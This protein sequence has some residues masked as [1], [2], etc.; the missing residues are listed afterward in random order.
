MERRRVLRSVIE[1][2]EELLELRQARLPRERVEDEE[3]QDVLVGQ[4]I[5]TV[6]LLSLEQFSN[7]GDELRPEVASVRVVFVAVGVLTDADNPN[8]TEENEHLNGN[9]DG[10]VF[11]LRPDEVA[12][13]LLL[14]PAVV[15][16]RAG[17]RADV[18]SALL[19]LG[20]RAAGRCRPIDERNRDALD[21]RQEQDRLK[22]R[23]V[24]ALLDVLPWLL[25]LTLAKD[26]DREVQRKAPGDLVVDGRDALVR[27]ERVDAR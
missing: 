15:H 5:P 11:D 19:V 25:V 26:E 9:F 3:H 24:E 6:P 23:R 22:V 16:K 18:H 4:D 12:H 2:E 17:Q 10:V 8:A 1:R 27:L 13:Q 7:G 14:E 21:R 20:E